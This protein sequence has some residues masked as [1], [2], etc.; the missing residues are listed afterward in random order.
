MPHFFLQ[1]KTK[2]Y[3]ITMLCVFTF[4]LLNKGPDFLKFLYEPYV[5]GDNSILFYYNH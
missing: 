4:E 3:K 5:I 2:A 1:M